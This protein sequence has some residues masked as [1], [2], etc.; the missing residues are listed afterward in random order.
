MAYTTFPSSLQQKWGK[1]ETEEFIR[2]LEEFLKDRSV[3]RDEYREILSRLDRV[4]VLLEQV[5]REQTLQR[6]E[7]EGFRKEVN[8][9]FDKVNERIEWLMKWT[10]GVIGV[11]GSLLAILM[12]IYRFM[13]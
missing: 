12:S 13:G 10:V 6:Q 5:V 8:E 9:R 11:V 3:T 4:D 2:W 7:L 1:Q